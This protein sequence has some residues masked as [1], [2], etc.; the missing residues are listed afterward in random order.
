MKEVEVMHTTH[1]Q[2]ASQKKLSKIAFKDGSS[3][4]ISM[5]RELFQCSSLESLA[6]KRMDVVEI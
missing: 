6:N 5:S 3:L 2:S 1:I 4:C